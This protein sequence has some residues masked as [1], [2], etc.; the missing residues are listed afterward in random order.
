MISKKLAIEVLNEMLST[1]ADYAEIFY[2]DSHSNG[3]SIENG[4]GE[5]AL[6]NGKSAY[7]SIEKLLIQVEKYKLLSEKLYVCSNYLNSL[8]IDDTI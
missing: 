2:E 1:G 4:N 6:W 3:V 8:A 5:I 7:S